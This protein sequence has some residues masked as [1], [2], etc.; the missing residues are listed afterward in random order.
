MRD[1]ESVAIKKI[2]IALFKLWPL[3]TNAAKPA[4][5]P[6]ANGAMTSPSPDIKIG[7]IFGD[8]IFDISFLNRSQRNTP[9]NLG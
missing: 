9:L 2:I 3:P 6:H 7:W 5:N 4:F 8:F 1:V